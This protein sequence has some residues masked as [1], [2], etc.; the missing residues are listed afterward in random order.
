MRGWSE[1]GVFLCGVQGPLV[2][3]RAAKVIELR[4]FRGLTETEAA[5]E[6]GNLD[7][8]IETGLGL[9]PKLVRAGVT[10]RRFRIGERT[11]TGPLVSPTG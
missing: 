9:R 1:K 4:F 11:G 8:H 5:E 10:I 6:L 2:I 7:Y 3:W